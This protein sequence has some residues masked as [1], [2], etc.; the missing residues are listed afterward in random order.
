MP[1]YRVRCPSCGAEQDVFRSFKDYDDLPICHERMERVICAAYVADDIKPY[2]SMVDG[3]VI[4]SRSA[5]RDH[6]KAHR[7]V[8]VGNETK[9]LQ[10]KPL[11]PPP[12]LKETIIRVANEKLRSK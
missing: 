1:I 10:P 4:S 6:L 8:E 9:Y 11:A 7:L 5:H 2:R 3:R 12:G